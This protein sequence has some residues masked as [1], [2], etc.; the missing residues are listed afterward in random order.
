MTKAIA[1]SELSHGSPN[2]LMSTVPPIVRL[3]GW[4]VLGSNLEDG[5]LKIK[6]DSNSEPEKCS[7]CRATAGNIV[8]MGVVSK[9]LAEA[10]IAGRPAV[11]IV[12]KRRYRCVQ[13][14]ASMA[15]GLPRAFEKRRITLRCRDHIIG[16]SNLLPAAEIALQIG[17]HRDTVSTV[18]AD[19]NVIVARGRRPSRE[20]NLQRCDFCT[21]I[22]ETLAGLK[23]HHISVP[24]GSAVPSWSLCASCHQQRAWSWFD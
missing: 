8:R 11:L 21:G 1:T 19:E 4:N 14:R 15:Q 12:A 7:N 23:A 3:P 18:L 5:R 13:C 9:T 22:F 6:V 16:Q 10:P 2:A 20:T 17:V 24:E